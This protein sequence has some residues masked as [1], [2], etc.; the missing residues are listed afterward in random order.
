[1]RVGFVGSGNVAAAMARGWA[2][3]RGEE[4]APE[5]LVFSDAGSGRAGALAGEV[6]GEVAADNRAL[7][8]SSDLVVLAV[9]PGALPE[10][11]GDL[12]EAG[13]PVVSLLGATPLATLA[14]ALPGIGLVRVMPNLGVEL[15]RGVLCV[16]YPPDGD[17]ELRSRVEGMLALLGSVIELEDELMDAATAVMGC[18]PGYLALIAKVLI[19]AGVQE[20]LPDA[21]TAK[22]VAGSMAATGAL[23]EAH[24]PVELREAVASPGGSTEAGLEALESRSIRETIRAAVD[25]SLE[26]MRG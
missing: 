25:A 3:A 7:A 16:A 20:G 2:S 23:L 1:M 18:T 5:K 8:E 26:R 21:D 11:A 15:R 9:K 19:D 4:G 17:P 12:A 14:D 10:V 13:R 24:D 22:M 6:G